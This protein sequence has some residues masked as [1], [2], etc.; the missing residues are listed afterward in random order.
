MMKAGWLTL[1][2]SLVAVPAWG[3]DVTLSDLN[4]VTVQ[5][6]GVF[7]QTLVRNAKTYS[8]RIYQT[9]SVTIEENTVRSTFQVTAIHP[10]GRRSVGPSRSIGP[11]TIGKP[12]KNISGN[13]TVWIFADGSLSRLIVHTAGGAGGSKLTI[14]FKQGP[15][16][17][18]CSFSQ[19]VDMHENGVGDI[20]KNAG[21]DGM[22]LQVLQRKQIS[23]Q[24]TVAKAPETT[25]NRTSDRRA[26]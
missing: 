1:G 13:D 10:D 18:A 20:R 25:A 9:G 16:G 24:C 2:L 19:P 17:L 5:V 14:E 7:Q 22:P 21:T 15:A 12:F 4:G 8:P 11:Q 26:Q 3:R 6:S 23:S